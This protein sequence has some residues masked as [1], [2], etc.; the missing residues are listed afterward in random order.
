MTTSTPRYHETTRGDFEHRWVEIIEAA[1]VTQEVLDAAEEI[2]DGWFADAS[3]IDW[4]DLL[5][6]LEGTHLD[7]HE[8]RKIDLGPQ[9]DSPAIRRI[10]RHIRA[11]RRQG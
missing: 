1:H 9:N 4:D 5:D 3:S 6:R 8:G 11:I 2:Y 7:E 10:K